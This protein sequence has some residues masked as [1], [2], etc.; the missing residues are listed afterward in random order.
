MKINY[1]YI[2]GLCVVIFL[3]FSV[4]TLHAYAD[5]G[6]QVCTNNPQSENVLDCNIL[7]R[8][9]LFSV[10]NKHQGVT[11]A[12][13][14]NPADKA[15]QIRNANIVYKD[16]LHWTAVR[17]SV[18]IGNLLTESQRKNYDPKSHAVEGF[19]VMWLNVKSV[20]ME[21]YY[22]QFWAQRSRAEDV[23][24]PAAVVPVLTPSN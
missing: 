2:Y 19:T 18:T 17:D 20:D 8:A 14:G 22:D 1:Q 24:T 16:F 6:S 21:A 12:V 4:G 13:S 9:I 7:R 10:R 23:T 15:A 5:T 11:P 3:S